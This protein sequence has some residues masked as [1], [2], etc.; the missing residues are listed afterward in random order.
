MAAM[1]TCGGGPARE[2]ITDRGDDSNPFCNALAEHGIAACIPP[3][4][5]RRPPIP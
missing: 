2:L 3:R 1:T 5:N 4:K